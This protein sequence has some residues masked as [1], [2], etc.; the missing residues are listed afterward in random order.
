MNAMT[1]SDAERAAIERAAEAMIAG[2][3]DPAP[4]DE[5][6]AVCDDVMRRI[7]LGSHAIALAR[8]IDATKLTAHGRAAR[9]P[10]ARVRA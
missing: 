1:L 9:R 8:E 4:E 10:H 6:A 7:R 2:R 5:I 3:Y